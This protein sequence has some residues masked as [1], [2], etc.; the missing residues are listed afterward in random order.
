[1]MLF[2][3][4]IETIVKTAQ[5]TIMDGQTRNLLG[6]VVV[7]DVLL[8]A[9]ELGGV[10][11]LGRDGD[12]DSRRVIKRLRIVTDLAGG[13][14]R[15]L[16]LCQWRTQLR[17]VDVVQFAEGVKLDRIRRYTDGYGVGTDDVERMAIVTEEAE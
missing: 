6:I 17:G 7:A 4:R 10:F 14:E 12:D 1:M 11:R 16:L 2:D 8:H 5:A 9:S 3:G 13:L 15:R